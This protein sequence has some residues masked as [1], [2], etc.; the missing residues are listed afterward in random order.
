MN[1]EAVLVQD[2]LTCLQGWKDSSWIFRELLK[3][4]ECA[5]RVRREGVLRS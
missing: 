4:I 5:L 2:S 1:E 3:N